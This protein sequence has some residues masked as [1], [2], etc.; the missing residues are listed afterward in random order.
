MQCIFTLFSSSG[1]ALVFRAPDGARHEVIWHVRTEV[2]FVALSAAA[3]RAYVAT[4]E[5]MDKAGAYGLQARAASFVAGLRGC[6]YNVV[7]LPLNSLCTKLLENVRLL[8]IDIGSGDGDG[9]EA[10]AV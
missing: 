2:E 10:A 5:P 8:G 4:G 3:I 6:Y 7:G 9:D 1:C